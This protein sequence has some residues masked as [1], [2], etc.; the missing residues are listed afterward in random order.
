MR[1]VLPLNSWSNGWTANPKV[2]IEDSPPTSRFTQILEE[3]A[4]ACI[5]I[6]RCGKSRSFSSSFIFN[7]LEP[8]FAPGSGPRRLKKDVLQQPGPERCSKPSMLRHA[9]VSLLSL[10]LFLLIMI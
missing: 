2:E 9:I 8:H 3:E 4:C 6:V 5:D 7:S 10:V 1:D